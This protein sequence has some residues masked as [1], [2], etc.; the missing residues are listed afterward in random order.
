LVLGG[1][2]PA[3]SSQAHRGKRYSRKSQASMLPLPL[4]FDCATSLED[5][6][7]F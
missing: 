7:G 5:K 6:K 2:K 4:N 3:G 1:V